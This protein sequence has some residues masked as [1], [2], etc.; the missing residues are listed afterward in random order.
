MKI[1]LLRAAMVL[2]AY[3]MSGCASTAQLPA[4]PAAADT[5]VRA[6]QPAPVTPSISPEVM[7][8]VM[9]AEIAGKRGQIDLALKKYK[10]LAYQTR[11]PEI[12][13]RAMRIATFAKDD[14][15]EL[16]KLAALWLDSA[17]DSSEPRQALAML[18][19]H[20]G[21]IG[22][23][24]EHLEYL[25]KHDPTFSYMRLV[26]LLGRQSNHDYASEAMDRISAAH[27]A[28]PEV[29]FAHAHLA[30]R[31]NRPQPALA[32]IDRALGLKP[33]WAEAVSLRSHILEAL[34]RQEDA[35]AYLK[36]QLHGEL[37]KDSALRLGYARLLLRAQQFDVAW[38]QLDMLAKQSP[39]D[40]ETLYLLG[41]TAAQLQRYDDAD[42]IFRKI[43]ALDDRVSDARFQLGR[44]AEIGEKPQEAIEWYRQVNEGQ[45]YFTAQMQIATLLARRGEIDTALTQL[46]S[47]Q[48]RTDQE[49][50]NVL[51]LKGEI[52]FRNRRYGE[53]ME[54]NNAALAQ[55]P[56]ESRLLYARALT[57]EKLDQLE[58]TERDLRRILEGNPEDATA[59]NAL[60]YTLVDRTD[61]HTEGLG[62]I[63]KAMQL[64]PDDPAILDSMG[65]AL[66]R[67]G[68]HQQAL[69]YLRQA[70]EKF[71]DAEIAAHLGEVLWTLGQ[72][73]EARQIW[74]DALGKSPDHDILK[75]TMRRFGQ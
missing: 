6:A 33:G 72:Q 3:G 67:V 56:D 27:A 29:W 18:L 61:R 8:D 13:E 62:Y 58:L 63:E 15:G 30:T 24:V 23:A 16:R 38:D 10:K 4:K 21:N 49:T 19:L 22:E 73:D 9:V 69:K 42:R 48:T 20:E 37:G 68:D 51:L 45:F 17:P 2:I 25:L 12:I 39:D 47:I 31:I 66:Y 55:F 35:V 36:D 14:A 71:H 70:L 32:H 65:W 75:G 1:H 40:T 59:L 26:T 5:G 74:G 7:Y 11:D 41:S 53:A 50:F 60:G 57:A 34:G 46:Q 43:I 64:R 28:N 54:V 52:L 44:L